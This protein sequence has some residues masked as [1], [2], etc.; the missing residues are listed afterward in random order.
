M[1]K[2]I[3][4]FLFLLIYN[5]TAI[6][7]ISDST[8]NCYSDEP[9]DKEKVF[10]KMLYKPYFKGGRDSFAN[11]LMTNISFQKLVGDL[12]PDER[13]YTDTARIKFIVSKEGKLSDLLITLTKRK[14]FI[15]EINK[16]IRKSACNW[17]AGGTE[18]L[19]NGWIQFDICY[20]IDRRLNDV[21][22]NFK[23]KEYDYAD[24]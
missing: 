23:I 21:T 4:I 12:S 19:V 7:Q 24:K 3:A 9:F 13:L 18:L 11:F 17:E 5:Q 22:I 15:D 1:T 20:L 14:V 10:T 8:N 16:V 6:S 2:G